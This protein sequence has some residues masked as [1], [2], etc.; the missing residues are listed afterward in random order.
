MESYQ[1]QKIPI[2]HHNLF[3]AAPGASS[4]EE[5]SFALLRSLDDPLRLRARIWSGTLAKSLVE[6]TLVAPAGGFLVEFF[7]LDLLYASC[8][9]SAK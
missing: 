7:A 2:N 3:F 9:T 6:L 5:M 4:K 8:G 1:L